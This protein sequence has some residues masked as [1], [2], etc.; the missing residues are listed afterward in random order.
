MIIW[1]EKALALAIHDRQLAEHGGGTGMRDEALLLSALA[2]PQRRLTYG[3]PPPAL[4]DLP[5]S[6]AFALARNHPFVD[7]NKRTAAVTCAT[8]I[9]LNGGELVADD[10]ALYP[11]YIALSDGSLPEAELGIGL[12]KHVVPTTDVNVQ[13]TRTRYAR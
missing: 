11:L 6:L 8:V 10:I 4:A 5:A 7:G 2:H 13:E 9:V 1:I 3:A 12:R